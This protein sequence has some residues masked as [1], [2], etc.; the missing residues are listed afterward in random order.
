MDAT[1]AGAL[2]TALSELY[3]PVFGAEEFDASAGYDPARDRR[4]QLEPIVHALGEQLRRL[5]RILDLGCAQGY[6]SLSLAAT[7][8]HV[9]GVD[10]E[11]ENIALCRALAA[12]HPELDVSFVLGSVEDEIAELASGD[13]DVVL[14]LN[15]F[16]HMCHE[17]GF[18]ATRQMLRDLAGKVEVLLA[19]TALRIEPLYWAES[20]P[21]DP[22]ELIAD[23]GF[24][25]CVAY[26]PN[27]L[28]DTVRPM[29]FASSRWWW[30]DAT[31]HPFDTWTEQSHELAGDFHRGSRRYFFGG[32]RL[33]KY[34]MFAGDA[35]DRNRLELTREIEFLSAPPAD[36]ERLPV[37]HGRAVEEHCGWLVRELLPG[38]RL[39]E[40]IASGESFDRQRVLTDVL[41]ALVT[42]EAVGLY[43]GDMRIWNVIVAPDGRSSIIDFGEITATPACAWPG[44]VFLS[45]LIFVHELFAD[46]LPRILP[47]R[48]PSFAPE[49]FNEPQRSWI[50]AIWRIAPADWSFRRVRDLLERSPE[51][52][53]PAPGIAPA[54]GAGSSWAAAI[55]QYIE[56]L[57]ARQQVLL[58]ESARRDEESAAIRSGQQLLEGAFAVA[59]LRAELERVRAD[60][61]ARGAVLEQSQA[62]A[63]AL[64]GA[65]S[66]MESQCAQLALEVASKDARLDR[67][68]EEARASELSLLQKT[69]ASQQ[70]LRRWRAS[71]R[72]SS[73][74]SWISTPNVTGSAS[75]R[76][77]GGRRRRS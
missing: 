56:V 42:L 64:R 40:L 9:R 29:F 4:A 28:S 47:M 74:G 53:D 44:N 43:H 17:H 65:L 52:A 2:V 37:V 1:E 68:V 14:A 13:F 16:H 19:E 48:T 34:F 76:T 70:R 61:A 11:A 46:R 51:T 6:F 54:A 23:F 31:L 3:Q 32:D 41:D 60:L 36:L 66:A 33:A 22:R 5:V 69:Q 18:A 55:E 20:L 58:G 38:K 24:V 10:R 50:A 35:A 7:G 8:A 30:L 67:A 63:A 75:R 27:H 45:F 26:F 73:N 39:S 77:G 15:V 57:A 21:A 71:E 25:H 62:D 72:P 49:H 12:E 59:D